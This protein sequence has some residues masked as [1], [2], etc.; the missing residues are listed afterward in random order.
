MVALCEPLPREDDPRKG[1]A[2]APAGSFGNDMAENSRTEK[3]ERER[4]VES[5]ANVNA[6]HTKL[7]ELVRLLARQTATE[8]IANQQSGLPNDHSD[9]SSSEVLLRHGN[10]GVTQGQPKNCPPLDRSR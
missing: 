1:R 7:V 5:P 6:S 4:G 8:F 10:G 3:K 9:L 2:P